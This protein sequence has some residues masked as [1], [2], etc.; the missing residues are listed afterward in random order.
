MRLFIAFNF[1]NKVKNYLSE[2]QSIIK[3]CALKG[4][5]TKYDNFHLTLR[6][7]GEIPDYE[8]DNI[9]D[10]IDIVSNQVKP[11]SIKIGSINSFSRKNKHI[12]YVD[13][14]KNKEGLYELAKLLNTLIDNK[15]RDAHVYNF[16][17]HITIARE[18]IFNEVSSLINVNPFNEEI[19]VDNITLFRSSRDKYQG[20]IYTPIYTKL[21]S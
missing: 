10:I 9:I 12:V 20:L 17:P 5:Y 8:V 14:L 6:F 16:K 2:V 21:L 19:I 7:L 13:V 15:I 1:N 11:F 3:T 18:V 4:N